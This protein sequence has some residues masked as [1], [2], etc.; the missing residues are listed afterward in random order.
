MEEKNN[1]K[2]VGRLIFAVLTERK[3]VKDALL[4]FPDIKDK[5]IECAYHALVH[6]EADSDIRYHDIE[7]REAQDEY[8]EFMAQTLVEGNSLPRNI[9]AD[10]EQYYK[11][12]AKPWK[13]GIK[14]F[15]KEFLRFI[16]L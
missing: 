5:S 1:R 13:N 8:L 12:T 14:G 15:C 3:T 2:F 6:Y 9:I 4:L 10:Y 7:Y 11:G 16:N